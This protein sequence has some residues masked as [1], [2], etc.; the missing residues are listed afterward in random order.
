M[1][2]ENRELVEGELE[3]LKSIFMDDMEAVDSPT[4]WKSVN[5][6]HQFRICVHSQEEELKDSVSIKIHFK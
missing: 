6:A 3:V 1:A 5:A 2:A 4:A